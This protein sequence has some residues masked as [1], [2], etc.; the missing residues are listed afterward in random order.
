MVAVELGFA[1]CKQGKV[2]WVFEV[3][4]DLRHPGRE[5]GRIEGVKDADGLG[6]IL[7]VKELVV[8]DQLPNESCRVGVAGEGPG[9]VVV[10]LVPTPVGA[11]GVD[12][13]VVEGGCVVR[14]GVRLGV[15]EMVPWAVDESVELEDTECL[16]KREVGDGAGGVLVP[17]ELGR[18]TLQLKEAQVRLG[19]WGL[20]DGKRLPQMDEELGNANLM[21]VRH[22]DDGV[23]G[24]VGFDVDGHGVIYLLPVQREICDEKGEWLLPPW[25]GGDRGRMGLFRGSWTYCGGFGTRGRQEVEKEGYPIPPYPR[26]T[27]RVARLR[28]QGK[29][30]SGEGY[31]KHSGFLYEKLIA[32]EVLGALLLFDNFSVVVHFSYFLYNFTKLPPFP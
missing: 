17:K 16:L 31:Q 24:A 5:Q 6:V 25:G 26:W 32:G 10:G 27:M 11:N 29:Q 21:V 23:R 28:G 8:I 18:G 7:E 12:G 15:L 3:L 20:R 13:E 22:E 1:R 2:A 30:G 9:E 4:V 19:F 14:E